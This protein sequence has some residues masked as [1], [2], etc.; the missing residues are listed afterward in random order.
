MPAVK[1]AWIFKK[2]GGGAAK[3]TQARLKKPPFG[4]GQ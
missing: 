3:A 2:H 1:F 4:Y